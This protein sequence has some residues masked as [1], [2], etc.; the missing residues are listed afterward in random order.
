MVSQNSCG[1]FNDAAIM[2]TSVVVVCSGNLGLKG[3]MILTYLGTYLTE[4]SDLY[5][6]DFPFYSIVSSSNGK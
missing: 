2:T 3:I 1:E 4:Q 5:S 6:E